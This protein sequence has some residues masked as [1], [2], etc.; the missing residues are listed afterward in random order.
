MI[1]IFFF[2]EDKMEYLTKSLENQHKK[3][4]KASWKNIKLHQN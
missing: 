1:L 2:E 4:Q 3:C